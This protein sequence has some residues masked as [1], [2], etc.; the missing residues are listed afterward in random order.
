MYCAYGFNICALGHV[1]KITMGLVDIDVSCF[2][3]C[4]MTCGKA[5]SNIK[6]QA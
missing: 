2:G 1:R 6:M 4:D 5:F 3:A